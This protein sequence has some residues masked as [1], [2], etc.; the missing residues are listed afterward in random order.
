MFTKCKNIFGLRKT[1]SNMAVLVDLGLYP[2]PIDALKLAV[3]FWHRVVNSNA[4]TL[5]LKLYGCLQSS[6]WYSAKTKMFFK[7]IDLITYGKIK[8]RS[9]T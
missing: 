6:D 3:G 7:R 5:K 1:A 4:N 2:C 9:E 8:I